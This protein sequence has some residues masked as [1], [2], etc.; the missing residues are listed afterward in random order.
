M[1]KHSE[2]IREILGFFPGEEVIH[3]DDLLLKE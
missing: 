3:R 2:E 1:G